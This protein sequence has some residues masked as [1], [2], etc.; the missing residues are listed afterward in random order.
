M[1]WPESVV[2]CAL[3]SWD[4]AGEFVFLSDI[5]LP[6]L[7]TSR[8]VQLGMICGTK[9]PPLQRRSQPSRAAEGTGREEEK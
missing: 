3:R 1:G 8:M 6:H 7:S 9:G 5:P 4:S 2:N